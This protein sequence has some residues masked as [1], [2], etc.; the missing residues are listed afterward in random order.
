ME[1]VSYIDYTCT[2]GD[3]FD[4]L[5]LRYYGNECMSTVIMQ[6]NRQHANVVMFDGGETLRIPVIYEDALP[7]SLPPWR[8]K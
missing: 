6:E 2:Q 5:A 3:T 1:I 7:E 8:R 4:A